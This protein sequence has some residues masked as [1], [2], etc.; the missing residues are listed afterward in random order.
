V[1]AH[2]AR[3]RNQSRVMAG[4]EEA[5]SGVA[6]PNPLVLFWRWRYELAI[7]LAFAGALWLLTAG[8]GV[9]AAVFGLAAGAALAVGVAPARRWMVARAWCVITPH[10]VRTA[11]A[12]ARIHTRRGRLPAVLFTKRTPLGERVYLWC[13]AGIS[14]EDFAGAGELLRTACLARALYVVRHHRWPAVVVLDVIRRD[15]PGPDAGPSLGWTHWREIPPIEEDP[16]A[17]LR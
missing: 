8:V 17:E 4:V 11:C 5:F 16:T 10:R 15:P 1:R 2:T 12:E 13:R 6:R 7:G 14:E 3:L 9:V